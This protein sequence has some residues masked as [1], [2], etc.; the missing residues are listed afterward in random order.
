MD[1]AKNLWAIWQYL[2]RWFQQVFTSP[3]WVRFAQWVTGLVLCDEEHT[4]TQEVTTL[5]LVDQWRN[6]ESFAEYGSFDIR[7]VESQ[8][9]R[10]VER[11]HPSSF[12]GYHMKAADDTKELRSSRD[13][14]GVCTYAHRNGRNP[15]R[16]K[17]VMAHNWVVCGDLVPGNGHEPWT[18]LPTASR[19]Y[20]RQSQLP[21]GE[22]FAT[23]DQ[24][25]LQMLQQANAD[26]LLKLLALLDGGLAHGP[27][28]RGCLEQPRPI[29]F[30]TRPRSDAR[31]YRPLPPEKKAASTQS[32]RRGK[33]KRGRKPQW[34]KRLPAPCKHRS[35]RI[36]WQS[37]KTWVYGRVRTFRCKMLECHWSVTGPRQLVH[38]FVFEVDGYEKPWY[39]VTSALDLT[40]AQVLEAY[41]ARFRLEDGIRDHKQRMGM[42][43]VRAWTKNPI[44]RTFCMQQLAITLLRLM[45]WRL[46]A[47]GV[48]CFTPSPWNPRKTR[49]SLLDLRRLLWRCRREFSQFTQ[50][51]G[52]LRKYHARAA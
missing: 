32:R 4:I 46:E 36:P 31:I 40:A 2:L 51:L 6:W 22:T 18:Y 10:L 48:P 14:W 30:I 13:I 3:G 47:D 37:G 44:L 52:E 25:V 43:Q 26:S 41:A 1:D 33:R 16:P 11:E 8:T 12:A 39:L 5:N 19:L 34:G 20:L 24:M 7:Q 27:L 23:K 21:P 29:N 45:Q 15:N 9:Q 35:W 38:V 49:T 50:R 28:L 42:E 17:L